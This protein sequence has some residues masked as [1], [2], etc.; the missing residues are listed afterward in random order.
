MALLDPLFGWQPVDE[1]FQQDA[2]LQRMLDF[3]AALAAAEAETGLIP[4]EAANVIAAHCRAELFDPDEIAAASAHAGNLAIPVV[5]QLTRKVANADERAAGYVHWGATSQDVI[6]TALILQLREAHILMEAAIVNARNRLG[7]L[8]LQ[9]KDT[10][11]AGR[12]WM[13]HA[14]PIV[15]GMKFAG[16]ADALNRHVTRLGEVSRRSL[17]L[18]FGGAAGTLASLGS[19]GLIIAQVLAR[20]LNLALPA[21]PWHTHRDRVAEFATALGLLIGTIGKIGR[22]LSLLS[23]SEVDELRE[24]SDDQRGGSSTMPQKRNPVSSAVMIAAATRSPGLVSTMLAAMVQEHERGLGGWHA[25]WEVLPELC[26]LAG[27]A[28][29]HLV[30]TLQGLEVNAEH[31]RENLD[32]TSGL[33][34]A[35]AVSAAL[36]RHTGKSRAHESV[37]A[38]SRNAIRTRQHLRSVLEKDDQVTQH[39]SIEEL[40]N[41]FSAAAYTGSSATF[42]D[43]VVSSWSE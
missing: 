35:E 21:I 36:A 28:V 37:A 5:Q 18:Q 26:R 7:D 11:M 1:V 32:V 13:Q 15:L 34:F 12:T 9:H 25:E 39:L 30:T 23:Q 2:A 38:C 42:I 17:A 40:D 4:I 24:P 16:W 14:V 10:P 33:I 31:M 27:G 43:R 29:H 22:D 19:R 41:L 3:E 20:K 6:D 8:A